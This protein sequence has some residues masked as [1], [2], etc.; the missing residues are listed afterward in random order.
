MKHLHIIVFLLFSIVSSAQEDIFDSATSA[1]SNGEYA[2]AIDL[3]QKVVEEGHGHNPD[4]NHNLA[5][6]YFKLDS[7]AESILY[8]ERALKFDPSHSEAKQNL[9]FANK[10]LDSLY[11]DVEDIFIIRW[12]RMFYLIFSSTMWA[13]LSIFFLAVAVLLTINKLFGKGEFVKYSKSPLIVVFFFLFFLSMLAGSQ[14]KSYAKSPDTAIIM[15]SFVLK[16]GPDERSDDKAELAKGEKIWIIDQ[17]EDWSK[18]SIRNK[19]FGWVKRSNYTV[20]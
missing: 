11:L 19:Q 7:L 10:K 5:W 3:Y 6:A 1:L 18:V 4:V 15:K 14:R 8:F 9:A 20:I 13:F 12:W 2:Q 16:S 17:I